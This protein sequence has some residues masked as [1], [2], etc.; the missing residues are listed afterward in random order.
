M[1]RLSLGEFARIV[2]DFGS[3]VPGTADYE[4]LT[5]ACLDVPEA[6]VL[7]RLDPYSPA[8]RDAAMDLYRLLRAAPEKNGYDPR[9]DER[10][11]VAGTAD[12]W[13]DV[14]PWSFRDPRFV[15]E[16]LY[17][18]GH[19]LKLLELDPAKGGSV[20]EYG[21]GSGQIVLLAARL[22]FAAHAVD[23]EPGFLSLIERQA[24][25][26]GLN[27]ATECA[28]FGEGFGERRFDRIIFFEA[29]HHAFDW[30]RLLP[31]L[32]ERLAEGGRLILAGEPIVGAPIAS[33]PFPWGPRLD[34]LSVFC[35]RRF[36]WMELGIQ[37]GFFLDALRRDGWQVEVHPFDGC[38]RAEAYVARPSGAPGPATF[39]AVAAVEQAEIA[40][41]KQALAAV[42]A[43]SSW[44]ITAPLRAAARLLGR[45]RGA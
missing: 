41:L 2:A 44:R 7:T 37:R 3:G 4:L 18:W 16:F 40:A 25:A 15:S 19:I 17:A 9:R 45:A 42:H 1:R 28:A 38:G 32:R 30:L 12:I 22:G 23:I 10:S 39:P 27:I 6:Q 5:T 14:T 35:M 21:P 33:I 34:A 11:D 36:G 8:Y 43:S 13:R 24:A 29:F 26:M 20:L 31:R